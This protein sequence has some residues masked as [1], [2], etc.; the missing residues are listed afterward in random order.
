MGVG[1]NESPFLR[2]C[3]SCWLSAPL[4]R[5][6]MPMSGLVVVFGL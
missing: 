3:M 4:L 1:E 6:C 2:R 5:L